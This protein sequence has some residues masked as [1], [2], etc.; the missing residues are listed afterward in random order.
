MVSMYAT[1]MRVGLL[2][3]FQ[4]R[5]AAYFYMIGML[6][7]PVVYLVVWSTIAREHGGSVDGYTPGTFGLSTC[8]GLDVPVTA[9]VDDENVGH[10]VPSF[11]R[12]IRRQAPWL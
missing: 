12:V 3:Q 11:E 5:A 6:A 7:E 9:V 4:Y 2:Q 10:E 1:L 8:H